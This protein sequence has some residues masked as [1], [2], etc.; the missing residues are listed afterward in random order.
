MTR[1]I[2][3]TDRQIASRHELLVPD[4]DMYEDVAS[5]L[6]EHSVIVSVGFFRRTYNCCCGRR[7]SD[8]NGYHRH[9][10]VIVAD[11]LSTELWL[12]IKDG[13][14]RMEDGHKED[15]GG[16]GVIDAADSAARMLKR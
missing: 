4:D 10:A 7:F 3:L 9:V 15:G 2:R 11:R 12:R 6:G 14:E 16:S 5:V 1:R 8:I 13:M